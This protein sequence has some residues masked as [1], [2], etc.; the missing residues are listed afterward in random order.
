[1]HA[2]VGCVVFNIEK[3]M[4]A[5]Q[6]EIQV[7]DFSRELLLLAIVSRLAVAPGCAYKRALR[8]Q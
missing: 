6:T 2:C 7:F 4:H 5:K 1:M 3:C 8:R